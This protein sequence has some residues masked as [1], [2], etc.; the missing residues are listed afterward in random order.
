MKIRYFDTREK[1]FKFVNRNR[2]K[3]IKKFFVKMMKNG[4]IKVIYEFS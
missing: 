4:K 2:N 3:K 1:Y